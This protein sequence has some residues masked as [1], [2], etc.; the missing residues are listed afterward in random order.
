MTKK[1]TRA[2][3]IRWANECFA[4]DNGLAAFARTKRGPVEVL[5]RWLF[6]R[7]ES[8]RGYAMWVLYMAECSAGSGNDDSAAIYGARNGRRDAAPW[9]SLER[10][11]LAD[12]ARIDARRRAA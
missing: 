9:E 10:V 5:R 11:I 4:C 8:R 2:G 3:L 7:S 12:L 6:G 1:L